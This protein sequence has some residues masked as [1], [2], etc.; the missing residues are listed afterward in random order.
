MI[1]KKLIWLVFAVSFL[2]LPSQSVLYLTSL[3][4]YEI[5]TVSKSMQLS[6]TLLFGL[7]VKYIH[8]F[9]FSFLFFFFSLN[10]NIF[11]LEWSLATEFSATNEFLKKW[12]DAQKFVY[13]KGAGWFVS[14]L[15]FFS[16]LSL[17]LKKRTIINQLID[18]IV[19]EL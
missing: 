13:G 10:N 1:M 8:L 9:F 15:S 2:P 17:Y 11:F 18:L 16:S 3:I 19:L 7:E 6:A 12:A 5:S 4:F 14:H